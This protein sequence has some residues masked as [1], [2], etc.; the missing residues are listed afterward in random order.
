MSKSKREVHFTEDRKKNP[1]FRK[2]RKNVEENEKW[3]DRVADLRNIL[4]N[5]D[6][7]EFEE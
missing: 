3:H 6:D 5:E 7:E 2:Q 4:D 1:H